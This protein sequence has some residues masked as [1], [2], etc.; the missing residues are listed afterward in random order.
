MRTH[1][2]LESDTLPNPARYFPVEPGPYQVAANLRNLGTDFGNGP[3]DARA[4]QI[5]SEF[6]RYYQNKIECRR[7]RLGKYYA[8]SH[9]KAP[10]AVASCRFLIER[11]LE[12]YPAL[13]RWSAS[14]STPGTGILHCS[15]TKQNLVFDQ[16]EFVSPRIEQGGP[17]ESAYQDGFDALVCQIPEDMAIVQREGEKDWLGAIHLCAAGHWAAEDKIGKD[18]PAVHSPV[19][20]ITPITRAARAM[21]HAMIHKGPFVRFVWG[22]GSD[23]RLNHHPVPPSDWEPSA[24]KGRSFTSVP[25][26]ECPF[27]L[28]LE[29]QVTY[30]LPE[31]EAAL[32]FIR[33][34]YIDGREIRNNPEERDRLLTSLRTMDPQSQSYK[35][36][37]DSMAPLL[38]WL[39]S[40]PS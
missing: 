8:T 27:Y 16:Y 6:L 13:F 29:R 33:V 21:V 3:A 4:I 40:N 2:W 34:Y 26:G 12:E 31:V 19:P 7:E 9:L 35:G 5:D 22:F 37:T 36:L 14:G 23:N 30:G 25:P 10:V 24:W 20:H 32:F 15:L 17:I 38:D 1:A 28:R 11:L 18:F 39:A